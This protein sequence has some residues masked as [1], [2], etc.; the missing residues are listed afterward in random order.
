VEWTLTA[1]KN[2]GFAAGQIWAAGL[3]RRRF[4]E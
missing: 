3:E 2:D 1:I 4:T